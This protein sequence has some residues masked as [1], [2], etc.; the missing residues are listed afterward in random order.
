MLASTDRQSE[1]SVKVEEGL[2]GEVHLPA[3]R[4]G[5]HRS[6]VGRVSSLACHPKLAHGSGERR[7][8]PVRGF[9]THCKPIFPV[10]LAFVTVMKIA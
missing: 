2:P 4:Y 9:D 7:M 6:P 8:V 10:K 5:G 3:G 1:A